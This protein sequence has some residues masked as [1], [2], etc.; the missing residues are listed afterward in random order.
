M[1]VMPCQPTH[2]SAINADFSSTNLNHSKST[3]PLK[4]EHTNKIVIYTA[5]IIFAALFA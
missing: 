5:N 3:P 1:V 4:I 2:V